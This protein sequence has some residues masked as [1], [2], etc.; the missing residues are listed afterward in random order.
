[1]KLN[2]NPVFSAARQWTW[3]RSPDFT[4][5]GAVDRVWREV[6]WHLPKMGPRTVPIILFIFL[7]KICEFYGAFWA[8]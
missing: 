4:L 5:G 2:G 8:S 6:L 3:I 7:V 1:M